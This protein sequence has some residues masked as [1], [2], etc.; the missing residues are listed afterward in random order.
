MSRLSMAFFSITFRSL[1]RRVWTEEP[2]PDRALRRLRIREPAMFPG[3]ILF[4]SSHRYIELLCGSLLVCI[5]ELELFGEYT[6]EVLIQPT[7]K[8]QVSLASMSSA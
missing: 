5:S 1:I 3:S 2:R 7:E 8:H 4:L 6:Y